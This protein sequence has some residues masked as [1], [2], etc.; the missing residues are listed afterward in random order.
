MRILT[1]VQIKPI[2]LREG[3]FTYPLNSNTKII[4]DRKSPSNKKM[5]ELVYQQGV[6]YGSVG[7][8]SDCL[9]NDDLLELEAKGMIK[10]KKID[11]K[12]STTAAAPDN[13]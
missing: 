8:C 1:V 13:R 7:D 10:V 5:H 4:L 12:T 9:S 6:Y 2:Q 11:R 3:G